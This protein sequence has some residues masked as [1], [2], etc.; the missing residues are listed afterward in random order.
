MG[1]Q[2]SSTEN[3]FDIDVV[4]AGSLDLQ[5]FDARSGCSG[6]QVWGDIAPQIDDGFNARHLRRSGLGAVEDAEI[7]AGT[8]GLDHVGRPRR[9][10]RSDRVGQKE[11]FEP[12]HD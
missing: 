10:D 5:E 9:S 11:D 12:T 4:E 8:Y 6:Q 1:E 7:V 2:Q 3:P